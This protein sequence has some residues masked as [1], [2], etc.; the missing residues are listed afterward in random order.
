[1]LFTSDNIPWPLIL[2]SDFTTVLDE[3]VSSERLRSKMNSLTNRLDPELA[4]IWAATSQVCA[5]VNAA[6]EKG[7]AKMTE[8]AFLH[9]MGS[10]MYRLLHQRFETG[11]LD[12]AFRMGL[13]AFSSP[14]FLHWN[15]VELPD[16]QFTSAYREALDRLNLTES[17]VAPRERLWLLMVGAMSMSHEPDGLAWLR[18]WLRMNIELCNVFTWDDM[19]DVLS[20]FLWIGLVYDKPGKVIFDSILLQ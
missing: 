10:I 2:A 5:Q 4:A 16:R 17:N 6:A 18:P 20:S 7:G 9:S 3:K 19:R 8:E 1:M 13:V 11:S 12:E 14:I 15:R